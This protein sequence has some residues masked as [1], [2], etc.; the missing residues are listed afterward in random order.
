MIKGFIMKMSTKTEKEMQADHAFSLQGIETDVFCCPLC[1][2]IAHLMGHH[3]S[4]ST[5]T[6][7]KRSCDMQTMLSL[8]F[9]AETNITHRDQTRE[10]LRFRTEADFLFDL[11]TAC[12]VYLPLN[13]CASFCAC[14]RACWP[15]CPTT[16]A[17]DP[18]ASVPWICR[19]PSPQSS[20]C[21]RRSS[22]PARRQN[23]E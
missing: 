22:R 17:P 1:D 9:K 11:S 5:R 7:R 19:F 23:S 12:P 8:C 14:L 13:L 15:I 10:K 20:P 6:C 16:L 2:I 3:V 4:C 21:R 18:L